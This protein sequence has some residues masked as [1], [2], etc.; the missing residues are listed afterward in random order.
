MSQTAA[1]FLP[2]W[3]PLADQL[4]RV[5]TR[6]GI[7]ASIA[8]VP[9]TERAAVLAEQLFALG[10]RDL[11]RLSIGS[12]TRY[13]DAD[14]RARVR[15]LVGAEV[16]WTQYRGEPTKTYY[17]LANEGEPIGY[18]STDGGASAEADPYD[19]TDAG[20]LDLWDPAGSGHIKWSPV[21]APSGVV[22]FMPVWASSSDVPVE[23]V[24]IIGIAAAFAG[25]PALIGEAVLGAQAA[26]AYPLAAKAVGSVAL[27]TVL[28][29]GD[30]ELAV[31]SA[32][33]SLVG[34]EFGNVVGS[35]LDSAQIGKIAAAAATA[36]VQ[37][38]DIDKAVL[39]SLVD[40]GARAM[41]EIDFPPGD[42]TDPVDMPTFYI[43]PGL[44]GDSGDW[45][46]LDDLGIDPGTVDTSEI[47][48]E[49]TDDLIALDID[50][51][52]LYPDE[53]GSLFLASGEF[54]EMSDVVFADSIYMDD[55][56]N[57]RAPDN[58][59]MIPSDE[60][61]NATVDELS[62]EIARQMDAAAGTVETSQPA[63][64]SRPAAIPP[65]ASQ[66]KW[67]TISD[68][69]KLLDAVG[70]LSAQLRATG[71]AIKTGTY[72]PPSGGTS[73]VGTPRNTPVG[74]P[75]TLPDGRVITN[76]GNGTQT[77]RF[78][79]GTTTTTSS[80]YAGQRGA[81]GGSLIPGVSN[82]VLLIGG[83]ALLAVALLARRR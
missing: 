39:R 15:G 8:G 80:S 44:L 26:A 9:T 65:A 66:T 22:V 54:V 45:M 36:A 51:S 64:P 1:L 35:G 34:A 25:F 19:S 13:T 42:F 21:A 24:A 52:S 32:A 17:F 58:S 48:A 71:N 10:V 40:I 5:W 37:G 4:L 72:R 12:V 57:I 11:S 68:T 55:E 47:L 30:V 82:Q 67:P 23:V 69:T 46:T 75:V 27:Q 81:G 50:P 38:G 3:Q 70:K 83:A 62:A 61:L 16:D 43:D 18:L 79:D 76:N 29:G 31:R 33:A 59:I 14:S 41:D 49:M 73:T 77:I 74:V 2:P 20:V 56:G 28:T 7:K 63:P 60:A 78:P 6:I 53:Y